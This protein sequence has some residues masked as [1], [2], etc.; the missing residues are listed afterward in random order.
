MTSITQRLP[1]IAKQPYIL[2]LIAWILSMIALPI[3]LWTIGDSIIP[4]AA[5]IGVI[6]QFSAVLIILYLAWGFR[7]T[8]IAFVVIAIVTFLMEY[9]GSTTDFPFGAYDYTPLLQPQIGG[10]PLAIPLAWFM[11]LPPSWAIA[12][13]ILRQNIATPARRALF[14]LISALA[15]TAWDLY[16]DPQMVGWGFWV[17]E[18][19]SG[20]FGIPWVN[21]FGWILTGMIVTA[22]VRPTQLPILPLIMVYGIVWILQAIGL[23]VFWGQ[24][25]PA[26]GG[27]IAMGSLLGLAYLRS[28]QKV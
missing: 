28:N 5:L 4:A 20:Y 18:N 8:A 27:F 24:V 9:I 21:F 11:M 17:W 25:G 22:L 2:P 6:L 15:I 7:R 14:V 26:I 19:P 3:G 10:V 13:L 12:Y 23:G 16:L 1:E